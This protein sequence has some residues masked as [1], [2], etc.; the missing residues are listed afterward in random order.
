SN[1]DS[2]F[3]PIHFNDVGQNEHQ[4]AITQVLNGKFTTIWPSSA[5]IR[6]PILPTPPWRA[7]STA[8]ESRSAGGAESHIAA[9]VSSS[10]KLFQ[11]IASGLLTGGIYALIGI[12]L[13]IVFGVMRVVN[14]AHGALVM[15][16]MY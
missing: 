14:F 10:E 8:A 5:A 9:S 12:G 1:L 15:V 6:Q 3:G 13:T 11:T 16:G 7:R 4:V 2:I